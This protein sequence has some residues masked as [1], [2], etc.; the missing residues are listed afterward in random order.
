MS[1]V[2][3]FEHINFRGGHKHVVAS[4]PNLASADDRFFNDRI[5]S[6][7]IES[8]RWQF[9]RDVNF[10]GPSSNVFGPG[11]YNWVENVGI[12]N[13]SVSSLRQVG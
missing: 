8:G 5:S 13:D 11:Q 1:G 2:I 7:V 12:P 3:L 6:F 4:E 9:F 10:T